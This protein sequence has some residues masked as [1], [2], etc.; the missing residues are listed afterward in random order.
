MRGCRKDL[1]PLAAVLDRQQP[2]GIGRC[3]LDVTDARMLGQPRN[4]IERQIGALE[5][6]IV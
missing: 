4:D 5:L 1:E 6:R 2:A 3:I